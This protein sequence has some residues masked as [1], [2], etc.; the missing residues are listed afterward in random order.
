MPLL[1]ATCFQ[2]TFCHFNPEGGDRDARG[3]FDTSPSLE[4]PCMSGRGRAMTSSMD[5]AF[6]IGTIVAFLLYGCSVL[7]N[8]GV[9]NGTFCA[10]LAKTKGVRCRAHTLFAREPPMMSQSDASRKQCYSTRH[11][12]TG[13]GT[14]LENLAKTWHDSYPR[15]LS[16]KMRRLPGRRRDGAT[17]EL[18]CT[19]VAKGNCGSYS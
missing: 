2:S 9:E 6:L 17:P 18:P 10:G 14:Q 19:L 8:L 4:I 1:G 16:S 3:Y 5:H 11:Y 13:T 15:L 7:I 12:A